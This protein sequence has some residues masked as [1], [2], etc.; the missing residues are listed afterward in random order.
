MFDIVHVKDKAGN[1]FA[2]RLKN[3]FVIGNAGDKKAAITLPKG[4][5]VKLSIAQERDQRISA[6]SR[7]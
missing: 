5:G 3:C 1:T 2:T 4:S 7:A 6:K